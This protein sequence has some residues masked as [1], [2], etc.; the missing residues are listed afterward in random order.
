LPD[1]ALEVARRAFE[2]FNRTFN[3][4]TPDLFRVLDPEIEWI[5]VLAVLEGR[6]YHGTEEVR[7]W[8]EDLKEYW[9]AFEVRPEQFRD[10]GDDR[11]LVLGAWRAQGRRGQVPLDFPQAAWLMHIRNGRLLRLQAFTDRR[12]ALEAAGLRESEFR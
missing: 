1:E 5:P 12:E 4:G 11:V 10:L 8:L 9:T 3:E 7:G 2:A 6:A